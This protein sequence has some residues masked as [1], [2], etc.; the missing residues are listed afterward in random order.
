[1]RGVKGAL[2][3]KTHV[4]T[5]IPDEHIPPTVTDIGL[6]SQHVHEARKVR[7]AEV[8]E[9]GV[10]ALSHGGLFPDGLF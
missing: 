8:Q 5:D 6:T 3:T 7:D 4:R 9:P 10:N 1:V 2:S